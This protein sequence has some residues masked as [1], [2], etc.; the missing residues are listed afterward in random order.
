[1]R[2]FG[3]TSGDGNQ[4]ANDLQDGNE[5]LELLSN[6]II[7]NAVVSP[8]FRLVEPV[9]LEDDGF[10]LGE[11]ADTQPLTGL[12]GA[13]FHLDLPPPTYDTL[14]QPPRP[15]LPTSFNFSHT[16]RAPPIALR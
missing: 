2:S 13:L 4:L 16:A 6:N 5:S 1:M 12:A 9:T 3:K 11:Q 14:W 7:L 8:M 15:E 10:A